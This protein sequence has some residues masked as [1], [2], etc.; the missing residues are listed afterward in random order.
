MAQGGHPFDTEARDELRSSQRRLLRTVDDSFVRSIAG[1]IDASELEVPDPDLYEDMLRKEACLLAQELGEV[2]EDL[3]VECRRGVRGYL[4]TQLGGYEVRVGATRIFPFNPF[5]T[6]EPV[7]ASSGDPPRET[8]GKLA[9][10]V[11]Y[12]IVADDIAGGEKDPR[13]GPARS[14]G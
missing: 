4:S 8:L 7:F 9:A 11:S 13:V 12:L 6:A 5:Q 1:S 10:L 14:K 3:E 2:L